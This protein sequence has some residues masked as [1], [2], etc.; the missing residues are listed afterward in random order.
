MGLPQESYRSSHQVPVPI[1]LRSSV[2]DM[3]AL[4]RSAFEELSSL[5]A[6]RKLELELKPL[7]PARGDEALIR[8]VFLNLLSNALKFTAD[9]ELGRIEVRARQL[10]RDTGCRFAK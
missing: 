7:P 5:H 9:R 4:A 2:L 8:Q 3:T 1:H 10:P 6:G